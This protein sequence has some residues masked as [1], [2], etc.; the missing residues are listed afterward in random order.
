MDELIEDEARLFLALL[1]PCLRKGD[2][3]SSTGIR[4]VQ[5]NYGLRLIEIVCCWLRLSQLGL[6]SFERQ[7]LLWALAFLKTY[8]TESQLVTRFEPVP[9]EKTFR[10]RVDT[11]VAALEQLDLVSV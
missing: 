6:V 3:Q 4:R 2:A 11:V 10:Q 8:D 5:G 9:T 1:S 7:H